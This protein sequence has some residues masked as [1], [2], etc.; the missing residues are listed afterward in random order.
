MLCR[1]GKIRGVIH[2][3]KNAPKG[4]E[5]RH[6]QANEA[7]YLYFVHKKNQNW[8]VEMEEPP[9]GP[10]P[11]EVNMQLQGA[12]LC[13]SALATVRELLMINCRQRHD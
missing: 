9:G 10:L 4:W 5:Q 12:H 3:A 8:R 2:E 6:N 11:V 7:R 1:I 13:Q